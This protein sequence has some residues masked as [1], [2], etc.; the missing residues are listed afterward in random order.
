[1]INIFSRFISVQLCAILL[2]AIGRFPF[3]MPTNEPLILLNRML[4][5]VVNLFALCCGVLFVLLL[6]LA[7][8]SV[9]KKLT[10][11]LVFY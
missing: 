3:N 4:F 6:L 11:K 8:D 7:N 1:M 5:G 9:E 2:A 10:V